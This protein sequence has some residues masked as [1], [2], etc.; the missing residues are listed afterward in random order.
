MLVVILLDDDVD[1]DGEFLIPY[2]HLQCYCSL[3]VEK[4]S[5]FYSIA[6]STTGC[7]AW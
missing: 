5:I 2:N 4:S 6:S 7:L 3:V 1:D